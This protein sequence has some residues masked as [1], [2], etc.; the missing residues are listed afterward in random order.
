MRIEI[1]RLY[2]ISSLSIIFT[3][4]QKMVIWYYNNYLEKKLIYCHFS[5]II[6][7]KTL[8]VMLLKKI[9]VDH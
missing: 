7:F 2:V 4:N 8:C 3:S 5:N 9:K 1:K 6:Q